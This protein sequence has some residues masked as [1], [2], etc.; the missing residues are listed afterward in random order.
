MALQMRSGYER[1]RAKMPSD[2]GVYI[3]TCRHTF[4]TDCADSPRLVH[5]DCGGERVRRQRPASG[6]A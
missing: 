6:D 1:R 5:P 3:R 2:D 4:C